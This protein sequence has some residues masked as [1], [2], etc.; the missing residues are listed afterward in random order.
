MAEADIN[1]LCEVAQKACGVSLFWVQVLQQVLVFLQA[2][3]SAINLTMGDPAFEL[4][5]NFIRDGGHTFLLGTVSAVALVPIPS[6]SAEHFSSRP[7]VFNQS[8]K[9][10]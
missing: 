2:E 7:V 8:R 3:D 9:V 5:Q 4:R 1:P 6:T 10:S